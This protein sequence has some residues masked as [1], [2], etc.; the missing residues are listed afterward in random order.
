MSKN[1]FRII[2]LGVSGLALEAIQQGCYGQGQAS[3]IDCRRAQINCQTSGGR[4]NCQDFP[5]DS[6][7]AWSANLVCQNYVDNHSND[8]NKYEIG[9]RNGCN[10]LKAA[11]RC[12]TPCQ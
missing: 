11:N 9:C 12:T 4:G 5:S 2:A 8:A 10:A 7:P 3:Q 1:F 6:P